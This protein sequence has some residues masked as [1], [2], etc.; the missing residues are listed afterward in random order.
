[1]EQEHCLLVSSGITARRTVLTL[2][3]RFPPLQGCGV[4]LESLFEKEQ[5]AVRR[6]VI[7]RVKR[8]ARLRRTTSRHSFGLLPGRKKCRLTDLVQV[9]DTSSLGARLVNARLEQTQRRA[10]SGYPD[11]QGDYF[12]THVTSTAIQMETR[13][14][15][16]L[17]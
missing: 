6:R 12:M 4:G 9:S 10:A 7:W 5:V 13:R 11:R 1:M 14:A 3:P 16:C 17:S 2:I 15:A 8:R